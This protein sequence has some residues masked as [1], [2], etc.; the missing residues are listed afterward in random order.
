[1][2]KKRAIILQVVCSLTALGTCWFS[3]LEKQNELTELRLY[4]P[5]LVREVRE[6]RENNAHLQYELQEL[7]SPQKLLELAQDPK[8]AH[9]KHPTCKNILVLEEQKTPSSSHVQ[10]AAGAP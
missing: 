8:F 6:I 7:Q 2:K 9:L 5:K 10:F 3:Y 4:A 1:M